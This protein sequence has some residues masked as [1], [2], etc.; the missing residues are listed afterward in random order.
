VTTQLA[1][2]KLLVASRHLTDPNF[3]ET[4]ILLLD[5]AKEGAMGVILNRP[6]EVDLAT[7]MPEIKALKKRKDIISLG[8]P[9]GR[10][11]VLLLVRS[12]HPL[13]RAQQIFGD[14]YIIANQKVLTHL[15]GAGNPNLKLRAFVGYAGWAPSQLEAEVSRRDWHIVSADATTVFDTAADK[16]WPTLIK[17]S[18][19]EWASNNLPLQVSFVVE[20]IA[21]RLLSSWRITADTT[22]F[23]RK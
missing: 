8:G 7:V 13:E 17:S 10:E 19:L 14:C 5:Y 1:K 15:I 23:H 11:N 6:T 20:S 12:P 2:G 9:V 22:R 4:V 18:E 21:T 3:A 16:M